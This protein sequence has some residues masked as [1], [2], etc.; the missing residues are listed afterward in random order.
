L[1]NPTYRLVPLLA[2]EVKVAS[3]SH[4][5]LQSTR[6]PM[7]SLRIGVIRSHSVSKVLPLELTLYSLNNRVMIWSA[8]GVFG[9]AA[10]VVGQADFASVAG[11]R[12]V[13]ISNNGMSFPT[14]LTLDSRDGLYLC[15]SSNHRVTYWP[16]VGNTYV[17]L[18]LSG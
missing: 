5:V 18:C 8:A 10:F 12:G 9:A 14:V 3:I 2:L 6:D 4:G 16:R 17:N 7:Q 11:N 15:D 1:A 13:A